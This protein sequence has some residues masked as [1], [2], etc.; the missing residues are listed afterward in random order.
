MEGNSG[1]DRIRL[2]GANI[3]FDTYP[4]A[5]TTRTDENI[6][7]TI[8]SNGNVGIGTTTPTALLDVN[9]NVLIA[10]D[11]IAEN[12]IVGSTNL[13]SE[14]NTKQNIINDDDLTIS[15]ILNLQ[16][17]LTNLQE[18]IDLNTTNILTKQ[19]TI[20]TATNLECNNLN[21]NGVLNI[22]KNLFF[23][24]IVIRRPTAFSGDTT[25]YIGVREI[26][27]WVNNSNILFD[28][29]NDL[30][31]YYAL[32]SDNET[33][34]GLVG[35]TALIYDNN[36]STDYEAMNTGTSSDIALIIKNIP[37]T[38]IYNIQSIVY[39]ARTGNQKTNQ[40]LSIELYNSGD[41]TTTLANTNIITSR[42]EVYR[43]D[44]HSINTY[45]LGF[46]SDE[47]PTQILNGGG[48]LV[49]EGAIFTSL[50]VEIN[51]DVFVSGAIIASSAFL[52]GVNINTTLED[53]LSRLIT[54]ENP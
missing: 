37:L 28:N 10:G 12:L 44:F 5:T 24:T 1:A 15:K 54:L 14:I 45:T 40:G 48:S 3:V 6:R 22:D 36:I 18:D 2:R 23:D 26:Q 21:V 32:W 50:E 29:A 7:M 47:S 17:S 16:S 38:S 34:V 51:A 19:T 52:N 9:G 43:F 41:L 13:I 39:Y 46:A 20:T 35:S 11:L 27:C 42:R 49:I 31:S 25:F 30:I 8:L 33:A 53:I 4:I